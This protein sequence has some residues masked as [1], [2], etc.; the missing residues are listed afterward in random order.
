MS[1]E[2]GPDPRTDGERTVRGRP[3]APG[4]GIG[5]LVSL[6]APTVGI[7]A[8]AETMPPE[9][10]REVLV[11]AIRDTGEALAALSLSLDPQAAEILEFQTAFLAD[12][13]LIEEINTVLG[14]ADDRPLAVWSRVMEAQI[15]PVEEEEDE[16]FRARAADLRDMERSVADRLAA[17]RTERRTIPHGSILCGDDLSPSTFLS[18]DRDRLEGIALARGSATSH[19]AMLARS[20]GIPMVVALAEPPAPGARAI[21]DGSGGNLVI[22]PSIS[23]LATFERRVEA[24]GVSDEILFAP[25]I[26]PSGERVGIHINVDDPSAVSEREWRACDGVGLMRS[27]FLFS[28]DGSPPDE[29]SQYSAYR[30]ILEHLDGRPAIIR[31]LDVGGDKPVAALDQPAES[32]PFLGLRGIRLCLARPSVFSL[33]L[34]ALMRAAVH[35]DLRIMLPM[36]CV[37]EEIDRTRR[38]CDELLTQLTDS[39]QKARRPPI[40][41]MIETP[42]A[43]LGARTLDA[44]FFSIG[45]N[46][47][48]QYTMA[49][50]RDGGTG[51]AELLD[52]THPVILRLIGETVA[53]G[54]ERGIEVGLC[55]D[56]ASDP[57]ATEAL[58]RC[59]LRKLSVA[60]AAIGA[61]KHRISQIEGEGT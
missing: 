15:R 14:T 40:G 49:A 36:V 24:A 28:S 60:P 8:S 51:V 22:H 4:T 45:S 25:A 10:I 17:V 39:G 44:D 13:G 50:S 61:V 58:L 42:V 48:I 33:Q 35:G 18:L 30:S 54:R 57:A 41:I 19:V 43:A 52:P 3:A 31:T 2:G 11:G 12:P 9:R 1:E 23:T 27:E 59:G 5:T 29:E 6:D 20:R 53:A 46:D 55:G 56:M 38:L 7:A 26:L 37:Q 47:L 21:V 16:Y 34:R 32:N